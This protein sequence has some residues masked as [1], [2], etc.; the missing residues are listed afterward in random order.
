MWTTL[1]HCYI[2]QLLFNLLAFCII[3]LISKVSSDC[4]HLEKS[5]ESSNNQFTV[6][7]T[8]ELSDYL[9]IQSD[10]AT[11]EVPVTVNRTDQQMQVSRTDQDDSSLKHRNIVQ[12][13]VF[14]EN[15]TQNQ[16]QTKKSLQKVCSPYTEVKIHQENV[17]QRNQVKGKQPDTSKS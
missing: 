1:S 15:L 8:V 2:N 9:L 17:Q 10:T 11:M 12:S 13:Q 7:D 3:A 6:T 14:V 16:E 5:D 4:N